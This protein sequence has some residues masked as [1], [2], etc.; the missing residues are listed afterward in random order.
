MI[1]KTYNLAKANR[2]YKLAKS[3]L[4]AKPVLE[5]QLSFKAE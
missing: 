3:I 5:T 1:A 2:V 4:T